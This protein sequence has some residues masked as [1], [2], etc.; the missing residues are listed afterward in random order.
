MTKDF[1]EICGRDMDTVPYRGLHILGAK[2][3]FHLCDTCELGFLSWIRNRRKDFEQLRDGEQIMQ[4]AKP[5]MTKKIFY[6]ECACYHR[7]HVLRFE[8][9]PDD[10]FMELS[11]SFHLDPNKPWYKRLWIGFKYVFGRTHPC[12]HFDNWILDADDAEKL[13]KMAE[14]VIELNKKREK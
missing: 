2:T 13:K 9:D 5:V 3:D 12:G 1:C 14:E 11:A 6:F 10:E 7:T 8:F 4:T